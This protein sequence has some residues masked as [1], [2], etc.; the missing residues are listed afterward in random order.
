MTTFGEL[1]RNKRLSLGLTLEE[2]V[3]EIGCSKSHLYKLEVGKVGPTLLM[4]KMIK[5]AYNLEWDDMFDC[6]IPAETLINRKELTND[7]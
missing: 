3:L 5:V 4:A 7:R 1:I 6:T 2:A